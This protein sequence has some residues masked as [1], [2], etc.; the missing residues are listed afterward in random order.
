MERP[1]VSLALRSVP[2]GAVFTVDGA[3]VGTAPATASVPGYTTVEVDA[4]LPD[5]EWH[6]RVY[7]R[8]PGDSLTVD[9]EQSK[10]ITRRIA[11]RSR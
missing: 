8:G 11:S 9:L 4:R 2:P 7:I 3:A 10:A 6:G 5:R 1:L